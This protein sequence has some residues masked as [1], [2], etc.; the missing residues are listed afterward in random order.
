[1]KRPCIVWMPRLHDDFIAV[2]DATVAVVGFCWLTRQ[3]RLY[4]SSASQHLNASVDSHTSLT[5]FL[6]RSNSSIKHLSFFV[7]CP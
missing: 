5:S 1:M 7:M 3:R 2:M 6:S 4:F